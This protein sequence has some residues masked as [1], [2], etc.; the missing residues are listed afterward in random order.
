MKPADRSLEI[1]AIG[2]GQA[3]GNI[4]AEFQRRGY[5]ALA[6]N[7]A[8]TDLS[9]LGEGRI[10]L[11]AS[12][13][14]YI[15][16]EGFDGAGSDITYGRECIA[17]H[18]D[19]IRAA[20]E[21][22]VRGAD[23]VV[24]TAG[25][26]GGTGSC[27]A[28]LNS[29][30]EGLSLPLVILTSLPHS[31]ES[32]I[33]K[34]N[35]L[36]G[37]SDLAQTPSY[38]WALFDNARLA[39]RYHDAS[40]DTYFETINREIVDP[41][42]VFN[43]LNDREGAHA[44]RSLD[45]ED[46][47]TLLLSGGVISYAAS[48]LARLDAND[49]L[50]S[51]RAALTENPMMPAGSSLSDVSYLGVVIEA[52]GRALAESPFSLYEEMA[53]QLKHETGGAAIYLGLYR[54]DAEDA[55]ITVRLLC[56]SHSLPSS[57]GRMLEEAEREAGTIHEKVQQSV[58]KL[59]L[60]GLEK[61]RLVRRPVPRGPRAAK[62][63]AS[64]GVR[65]EDDSLDQPGSRGSA[66]AEPIVG[67]PRQAPTPARPPVAAAPEVA[68]VRSEPRKAPTPPVATAPPAPAPRTSKVEELRRMVVTGGARESS[69][70][71][72]PPVDP[73]RGRYE[74]L[75]NAFRD[76]KSEDKR[77]Y[78]ARELVAAQR[79]GEALERFY[80]VH[81]MVRVDPGYFREALQNAAKDADPHVADLARRALEKLAGSH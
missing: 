73:S 38:G 7:T 60:G 31:Y 2:L 34:V 29:L 78:I 69:V 74:R 27:I 17:A 80:A 62:R 36:R 16:L 13:R 71:T 50:E 65:G 28:D 5:R 37:V 10:A 43:R 58:Q 66:P 21:Q 57:I 12:Q 9:S 25:L 8:Q 24:L 67:P 4:A 1:V 45:G 63:G 61:L 59:D 68:P 46:F 47:R 18:A 42:D 52:P 54:L 56:S 15:G 39:R 72:A 33:A 76:T 49:V 40:I 75:A 14:I 44:I 22:H 19:T 55:P 32:G 51:V 23:V 30:L 20:V 64:R 53:Q 77:L 3:G 70:E 35:A 81:A 41:L 79:S 11:P 48:R 6:F 26:G